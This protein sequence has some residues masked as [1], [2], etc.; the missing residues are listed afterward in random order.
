MDSMLTVPQ[1]GEA[2]SCTVSYNIVTSLITPHKE[3]G[4]EYSCSA[5][6]ILAAKRKWVTMK[7]TKGFSTC[8]IIQM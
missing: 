8:D 3:M 5:P 4:R 2:L 7:V 1:F 6:T